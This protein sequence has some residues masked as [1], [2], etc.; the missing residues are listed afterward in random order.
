MGVGTSRRVPTWRRSRT[1]RRAVPDQPELGR[2]DERCARRD[3]RQQLRTTRPS[4]RRR[5]VRADGVRERREPALAASRARAKLPSG[6]RS[7]AT[8]EEILRQRSPKA[9]ARLLG[10]WPAPRVAQRR[11]AARRRRFP[12]ARFRTMVSSDSVALFAAVPRWSRRPLRACR[13]GGPA[14]AAGSHERRRPRIDV[15]RWRAARARRLPPLPPVVSAGLS[16]GCRR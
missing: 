1:S 2:D 10:G 3:H 14:R 11:S 9:Y 7:A 15:R 6:R 4:R 8:A 16:S 13:R 12:Q 5:G